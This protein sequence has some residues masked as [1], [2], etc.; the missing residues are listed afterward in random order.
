MLLKRHLRSAAKSGLI[1]LVGPPARRCL[2]ARSDR[3]PVRARLTLPV[4]RPGQVGGDPVERA[5]LH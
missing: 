4:F 2:M 3:A 1:S 5:D